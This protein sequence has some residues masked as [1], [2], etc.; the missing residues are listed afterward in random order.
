MCA[1]EEAEIEKK[2]LSL[3]HLDIDALRV[4]LRADRLDIDE[5]RRDGQGRGV[6]CEAHGAKL[7]GFGVIYL[8]IRRQ[9]LFLVSL[10]LSLSFSLL[11]PSLTE[12][13]VGAK[14]SPVTAAFTPE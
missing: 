12:R 7:F 8:L 4:D 1:V 6:C 2:K 13:S 9:F 3:A 10:S 11:F 5:V 14:L